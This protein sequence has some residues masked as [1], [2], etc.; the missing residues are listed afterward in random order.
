MPALKTKTK[1]VKTRALQ[2]VRE[3]PAN[4]SWDDLMYRIYVRQKIEAGI[5][6]LQAGRTHSH[7]SIRRE[8][9]LYGRCTGIDHNV[10][11]TPF[12]SPACFSSALAYSGS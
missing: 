3:L 1:G 6:D 5:A 8:F 4:S 2:L 12:S 9:G 11:S 7:E 10:T